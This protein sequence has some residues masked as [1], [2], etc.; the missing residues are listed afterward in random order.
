M[1]GTDHDDA[2]RDGNAVVDRRAVRI[3]AVQQTECT[4]C[5]DVEDIE[6]PVSPVPWHHRCGHRRSGCQSDAGAKAPSQCNHDADHDRGGED[7]LG[8]AEEIRVEKECEG[9]AGDCRD[10]GGFRWLG[11]HHRSSGEEQRAGDR[12]QQQRRRIC[13]PRADHQR[14]DDRDR[15]QKGGIAG[16]ER[17]ACGAARPSQRR[18]PACRGWRGNS[19]HSP[20][21]RAA[22]SRN[23]GRYGARLASRSLLGR[24]PSE[25]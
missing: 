20:H 22:S 2:G 12:Q 23:P 15:S 4:G 16:A 17:Q 6:E 25:A 24:W 1:L 14:N 11:G 21:P 19:R 10:P 8:S 3:A 13:R 9:T 7:D 5:L 18:S